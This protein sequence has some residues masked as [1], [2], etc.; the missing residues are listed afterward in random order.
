[1]RPVGHGG[2]DLHAPVHGAGMHYQRIGFGAAQLGFVKAE[3]MEIFFHG[4]DEGAGHALALKAQHHDD[5]RVLQAALH[6]AMHLDPILVDAGGQ[7]RGGCHHAHARTHGGQKQHVGARHARMH[8]VS[9]DGDGEAFDAAFVAADGEGVQQRLGGMLVGAVAGIHDAT[10]H[11][12]R[13]QRDGAGGVM[14]HHQNVGVHGVE[15][16]GGVDQGFPLLH[17]GIAHR[18]VHHVGAEP[19]AGNLERGLRPGRGFKEQV[20][21]GAP[22]QRCA[23]LLDLA[24]EID[25]F[26]GEVEQ[27]ADLLGG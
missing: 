1:M 4:G 6:A 2:I 26:F 15:R 5:V 22:A 13:Q 16:H 19:L 8:D 17:R 21:L 12:A 11:L 7:Q 14:A 18:H 9:A 3:I 10:I 23:L 20:D 24:V 25:E 27:P